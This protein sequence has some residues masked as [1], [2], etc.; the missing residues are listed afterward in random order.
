LDED[1]KNRRSS[2]HH[3]KKRGK[4]INKRSTYTLIN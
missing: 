1:K 2:T 4:G 3:T